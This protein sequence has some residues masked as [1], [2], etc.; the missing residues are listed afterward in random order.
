MLVYG[1]DDPVGLY[2]LAQI[3]HLVTVVFQQH[4]NYILA[5]VVDIALYR[6]QHDLHVLGRGI[7]RKT[8]LDD[9]KAAFCGFGSA[10]QLGQEYL[11]L[12]VQ[13]AYAV[14]SGDELV[15]DDIESR[16][17]GQELFCLFGDGRF[18]A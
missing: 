6:G 3:Y 17:G 13:L 10:H 18:S 16:H 1:F 9:V 7:G 14:E 5:D 11:A 2:I 12:F 15:I 4:F 8:G